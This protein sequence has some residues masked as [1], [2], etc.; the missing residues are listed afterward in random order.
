MN[1]SNED[2]RLGPRVPVAP[3]LPIA[4]PL[5]SR[6]RTLPDLLVGVRLMPRYRGPRH[7]YVDAQARSHCPDAITHQTARLKN[8]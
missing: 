5:A 3:R 1:L 4:Y 6:R 2:Q 8:P 7:H